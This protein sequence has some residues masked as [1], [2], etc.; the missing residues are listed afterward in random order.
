MP[1]SDWFYEN[2]C[3]SIFV[4]GLAKCAY[5]TDN[6]TFISMLY[7]KDGYKPTKLHINPNMA[8]KTNYQCSSFGPNFGGDND[9]HLKSNAISMEES[10][11][12][13]GNTY[14]YDTLQV[15]WAVTK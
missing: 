12:G 6:D 5:A 7:N 4:L 8:N 13:C 3:G 15:T 11:T 9:I 14:R 10:Y 1:S 2:L